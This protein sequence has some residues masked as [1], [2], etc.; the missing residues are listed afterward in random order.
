MTTAGVR[1]PT[2]YRALLFLVAATLAGCSRAPSIDLLGS[3]FPSWLVCLILA[4]VLTFV[5]RFGLLRFNVKIAYPVVVY[6]SLVAL[7]TFLFWLIFF[8]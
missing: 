5:V 6:P 1:R 4:V 8:Y 2:K 7:F 3:F